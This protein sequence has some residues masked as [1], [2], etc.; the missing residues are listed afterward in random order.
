MTK[1]ILLPL[2]LSSVAVV[3]LAGCAPVYGFSGARVSDDRDI[4]SVDSV[5]VRTDG[6]LSVTVGDT[7]SLRISA[8]QGIIDRLTSD[9]VDGVLVLGVQGPTFGFDFGRITYEL[10]VPELSS[11]SIEGSSDVTADFTG[12]DVVLISIDGSG[13][14]DGSGIDAQSVTTEVSGSGDIELTGRTDEQVVDISGSADFGGEDL[15]SRTTR[16]SL[17]GSGDIEVHATETLDAEI[18]GSGEVRYRGG[19]AVTSEVSGSGSVRED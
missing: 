11:L 17:S 13:D 16:V 3:A 1:R 7:P 18:S 19:A 5:E 10:T 2:V 8:P 15:I 12:A 6:D 9:V 4:E 14:V